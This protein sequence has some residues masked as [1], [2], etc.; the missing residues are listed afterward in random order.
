MLLEGLAEG[1]AE[2]THALRDYAR[3]A[4]GGGIDVVSTIFDGR[5]GVVDGVAR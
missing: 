1:F 3:E 4:A 5:G 2:D